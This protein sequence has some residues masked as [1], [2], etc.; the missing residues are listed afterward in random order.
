MALVAPDVHPMIEE[1]PCCVMLAEERQIEGSQLL[2]L[3]LLVDVFT[4]VLPAPLP[5]P[6][7]QGATCRQLYFPHYLHACIGPYSCC[8]LGFIP[9]LLLQGMSSLEQ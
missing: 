9:A 5:H 8:V 4:R 3:S 6:H 7:P 1:T 2:L